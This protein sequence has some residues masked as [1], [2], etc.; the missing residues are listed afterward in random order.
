M[1][2]ETRVLASCVWL[3]S[4]QA[5]SMCNAVL[6]HCGEEPHSMVHQF[7]PPS[8]LDLFPTAVCDTAVNTGVQTA[9]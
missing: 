4:Q 9:V 2:V 8:T 6:T 5:S 3:V 7:V 1:Q